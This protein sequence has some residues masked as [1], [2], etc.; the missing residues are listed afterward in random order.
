MNKIY[1][2]IFNKI[3]NKSI[4]VSELAKGNRKSQTNKV[5]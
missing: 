1:K 4:V 2:I 3:T 5:A